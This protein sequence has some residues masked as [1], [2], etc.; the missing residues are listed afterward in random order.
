MHRLSPRRAAL[1]RAAHARRAARGDG[2]TSRRAPACAAA[3]ISGLRVS[4]DREAFPA[5]IVD[6]CGRGAAARL[7]P[8]ADALDASAA[9]S[10]TREPCLISISTF[11]PSARWCAGS[12]RARSATSARIAGNLATAS[13]IGDT[14][15]CLM[16]LDATVTLA[17][18]ARR[19]ATLPVGRRSSPA[20]ARPRWR[21]TR[22]SQRSAFRCLQPGQQFSAYKLSKRFDQDISTVIAAFRLRVDGGKVASIARRLWRHGGARQARAHMLEAAVTGTPWTAGLARRY[23]RR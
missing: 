21:R 18:A 2:A 7:G 16:A 14:V 8:S 1:S 12:A 17:L 20:I 11:R 15:P 19:R 4:K 3:P 13:P 10:P 9:P 23:R 5:V 6:R 22:S